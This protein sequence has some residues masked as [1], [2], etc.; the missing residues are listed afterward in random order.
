MKHIWTNT[1]ILG[2]M[3][4]GLTALQAAPQAPGDDEGWYHNRESFYHGQDWRMRLFDRVREDL[5]RVQ[6]AAFPGGDEYRINRTM[7][8]LNDL[9]GKLTA[10]R[11]DEPEL[12]SVIGSLGK[13]VS[14]NR[15]SPRYRD[16]LNDDLA[17]LRDYREHHENWR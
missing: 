10:G 16:M 9:Q 7:Q 4:F 3:L 15:L 13:V 12:D 8:D 17:R 6:T 2:A 11:Y 1:A 14:D 5:N